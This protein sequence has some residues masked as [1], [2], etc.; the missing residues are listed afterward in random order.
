MNVSQRAR[1]DC[2]EGSSALVQSPE[3]DARSLASSNM[4]T[5]P[6]NV[7]MSG[8]RA[9]A[10]RDDVDAPYGRATAARCRV[11]WVLVYVYAGWVTGRSCDVRLVAVVEDPGAGRAL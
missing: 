5:V 1:N 8:D 2:R 7:L 3:R 11:A 6:A 4:S 10:E 9:A